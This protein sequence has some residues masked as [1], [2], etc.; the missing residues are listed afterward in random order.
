MDLS[1]FLPLGEMGCYSSNSSK[2]ITL[3]FSFPQGK[4]D[5]VCLPIK[6]LVGVIRFSD[7][8][9]EEENPTNQNSPPLSNRNTYLIYNDY[10]YKIST[11]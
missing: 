3:T 4:K 10:D 9:C 6:F 8:R 2:R 11:R 5:V 1:Y 7:E